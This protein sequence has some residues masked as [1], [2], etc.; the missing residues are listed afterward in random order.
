MN[1]GEAKAIARR[2]VTEH[3]AEVPGLL[4]VLMAGSMNYRPEDSEYHPTSDV[5]LWHVM[6]GDPDFLGHKEVMCQGVLLELAGKPS[7]QFADAETVL[8]S[9]VNASQLQTPSVIYDPTGRLTA[10]QREVAKRFGEPRYV[11]ARCAG[12]ESSVQRGTLPGM[13]SSATLSERI[14]AFTFTGLTIR[15]LPLVAAGRPPTFRRSAMLF[16]DEMTARARGELAERMLEYIGSARMSRTDAEQLLTAC[17]AAYDR[18]LE[19]KRSPVPFGFKVCP[20]SRQHMIDGSR[21]LI[22]QGYP[23]EAVWWIQAVHYAA[24]NVLE[25]DAPDEWERVYR[26]PYQRLLDAL[27]IG[28]LEAVAAKVPLAEELLSRTMAVAEEIMETSADLRV[29]PV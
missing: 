6:E 24:H 8:T 15:E 14:V 27:G 23:R 21:E 10:I 12:I 4:G 13:V 2:W 3:A 22:D 16:T 26:E 11:K 25:R 7:A 1:V 17:T 28:S 5:D 18:A 19:V 29:E 20:A 9:W